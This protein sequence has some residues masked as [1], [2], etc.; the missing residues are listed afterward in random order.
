MEDI[1]QVVV[2]VMI[3]MIAIAKQFIG[4]GE[5]PKEASSPQDVLTE[6]FPELIEEEEEQPPVMQK[7]KVQQ[8]KPLRR[9]PYAQPMNAVSSTPSVKTSKE[10]TRKPERPSPVRLS[11]RE[12]ARRAFIYSEIFNRKY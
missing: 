12:E 1:F 11:N 8:P 4:K 3:A 6:M 2:F 10:E 7:V 5:K 9:K